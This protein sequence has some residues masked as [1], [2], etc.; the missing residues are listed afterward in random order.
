MNNFVASRVTRNGSI[1]LFSKLCTSRLTLP[2]AWSFVTVALWISAKP[3]THAICLR[4]FMFLAC[5]G[6]FKQFFYWILV[7]CKALDTTC[8]RK[9]VHNYSFPIN[10]L[11]Q[12]C[13]IQ[14]MKNITLDKIP[15]KFSL[16]NS[17][18]RRHTPY[19]RQTSCLQVLQG[20][21]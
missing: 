13:K 1:K 12:F 11:T 16:F 8:I 5:S 4:V 20:Y 15:G 21:M 3:V 7:S 2:L 14:K 10:Y 19:G 6:L 9:N 17:V 18:K